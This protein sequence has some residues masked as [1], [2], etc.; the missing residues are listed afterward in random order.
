MYFTVCYAAARCEVAPDFLS[1]GAHPQNKYFSQVNGMIMEVHGKRS[2][3]ILT[4]YIQHC[5]YNALM[6]RTSL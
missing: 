5:S 1:H 3:Y 2:V 4:L 6:L